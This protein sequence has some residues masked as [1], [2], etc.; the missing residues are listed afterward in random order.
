[1]E[2]LARRTTRARGRSLTSRARSN[3]RPVVVF[4]ERVDA[5]PARMTV[6]AVCGA[7]PVESSRTSRRPRAMPASPGSTLAIAPGLDVTTPHHRALARAMTTRARLWTEMAHHDCVT[8]MCSSTMTRSE[9]NVTAQV[10]GSRPSGLAR[11]AE[12]LESEYGY[13]EVNLNCGCPSERVCRKEDETSSF[14]AAM[15]LNVENTAECVRRMAEAVDATK[16]TV[17]HRLGVRFD[18]TM[19]VEEETDSYEHAVKFI[20]AIKDAAGVDHFIVH[21]RSAVM[22]GLSPD[23]NR[24]IPPLR[25]DEVFA[26][27]D[28]FGKCDFTLNGGVET[29]EQAKGLLEREDGKLAGVMMGRAFYKHP[30]MLAD[31]DRVIFGEPTADP[32]PTRRSLV[33][34]YGDYGDSVFAG[35]GS[36]VHYKVRKSMARRLFKAVSAISYGTSTGSRAFHREADNHLLKRHY[37]DYPANPEDDRPW[38]VNFREFVEG[39]IDE[40]YLDDPL[41][42][43]NP[44]GDNTRPLARKFVR[45]LKLK[46]ANEK[47][48]DSNAETA[49]G[50]DGE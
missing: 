20:E 37:D 49:I 15:M 46:D 6:V 12:I 29:L 32:P 31:I 28:E 40:E 10:G 21:A 22:G 4:A 11:A 42:N 9:T 17:K 45:A 24:K 41:V 23:A 27:C 34:M 26:L 36:D 47:L 2:I 44:E 30:C 8:R 1:M 43:V 3:A 13:D 50:K 18:K 35:L 39:I 48:K 38:S 25:Y 33:K 7:P 16:I 14:G 19:T 5:T